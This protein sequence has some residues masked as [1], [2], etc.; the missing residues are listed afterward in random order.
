MEWTA[1]LPHRSY[2]EKIP[3]WFVIDAA[4]D[5]HTVSEERV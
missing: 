1:S 5:R 2:K 3:V 4:I